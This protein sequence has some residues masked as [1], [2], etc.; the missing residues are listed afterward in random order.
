MSTVLP[1]D[2]AFSKGLAMLIRSA[3]NGSI[4]G[5][6]SARAIAAACRP[7]LGLIGLLLLSCP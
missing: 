5:E 7:A 6:A 2:F 4:E 3:T 1:Q